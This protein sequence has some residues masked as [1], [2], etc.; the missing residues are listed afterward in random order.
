MEPH[1]NLK[2]LKHSI[3]TQLYSS[4][5]T[6]HFHI[7]ASSYRTVAPFDLPMQNIIIYML[8]IDDT[9]CYTLI[10]HTKSSGDGQ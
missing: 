1:A 4:I 8:L 7:I 2:L 9:K 5:S 10:S 6:Y 3:T